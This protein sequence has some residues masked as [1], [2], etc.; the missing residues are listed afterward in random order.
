MIIEQS[1]EVV[2][3]DQLD[4]QIALVEPVITAVIQDRLEIAEAADLATLLA[5]RV[6]LKASFILCAT[7]ESML[8]F[9]IGKF[10][11]TTTPSHLRFRHVHSL[12][13]QLLPVPYPSPLYSSPP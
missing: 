5:A 12:H 4:L 3:Q 1:I 2:D 7:V 11:S 13:H 6:E 9:L 10:P 8:I